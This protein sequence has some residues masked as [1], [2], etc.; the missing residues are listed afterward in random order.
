MN[1]RKRKIMRKHILKKMEIAKEKYIKQIKTEKNFN[2]YRKQK[3]FIK[4]K[5]L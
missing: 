1:E 2:D 4:T 5:L 3:F